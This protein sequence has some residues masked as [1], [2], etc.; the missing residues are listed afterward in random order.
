MSVVLGVP[1]ETGSQSGNAIL[2]LQLQ[3]SQEEVIQGEIDR[4]K[5]HN[6][7]KPVSR[8]IATD[9]KKIARTVLIRDFTNLK[10]LVQD[11]N[12]AVFVDNK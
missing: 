4:L 8:N 6:C 3:G 11:G 2:E 12:E 9:G 5:P 1:Q 10:Y 7:G